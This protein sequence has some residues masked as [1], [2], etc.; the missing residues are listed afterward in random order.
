MSI[1]IPLRSEQATA[2]QQKPMLEVKDLVVR[3]G[4]GRKAAAALPPSTGGSASPSSP[5]KLLAWW[6]GVGGVR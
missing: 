4:R 5:A 6:G 3:Y 1:E 2:A